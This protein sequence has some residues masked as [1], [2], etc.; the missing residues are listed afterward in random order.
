MNRPLTGH[1]DRLTTPMLERISARAAE[2]AALFTKRRDAEWRR[3]YEKEQEAAEAELRRRAEGEPLKE[4]PAAATH[5]VGAEQTRAMSGAWKL[6]PSEVSW[7]TSGSSSISTGKGPTRY[8][9]TPARKRL[10]L[11]LRHVP[12]GISVQAAEDGPFTRTQAKQAKQRLWVELFPRL[13]AE[14]AKALRIP[15]R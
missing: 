5:R 12:T 1:F 7:G 10:T 11:T 13:E 15:G 3:Y 8:R 6:D 9:G 4:S 2:R 14:V